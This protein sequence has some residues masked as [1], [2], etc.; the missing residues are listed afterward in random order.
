[1][2]AK[3]NRLKKTADFKK[4]FKDGK[5]A[6]GDLTEMRFLQN[7][8]DFCRFGFIISLGV[9]KKA[10]VRNKIR[11]RLMEAV[12]LF[13]PPIKKGYDIIFIVKPKIVGRTQLDLI[14]NVE[15]I[16]RKTRIYP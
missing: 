14:K 8:L 1:M 12:K 3:R 2:F 4:V 10:T 5:R 7:S 9:S 16:L 6:A 11:R 15:Q 13:T